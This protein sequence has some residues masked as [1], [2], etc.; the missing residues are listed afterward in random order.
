MP[1]QKESGTLDPLGVAQAGRLVLA[2]E[3]D[4]RQRL[5]REVIRRGEVHGTPGAGEGTVERVGTGV[6]A[7][8]G[9][10]CF[11]FTPEALQPVAA[12]MR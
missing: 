12:V 10:E 9:G 4:D 7:V 2:E 3:E 11:R 1:V 8:E 6:E 5:M